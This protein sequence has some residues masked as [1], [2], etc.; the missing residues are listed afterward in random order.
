MGCKSSKPV[1]EPTKKG[2]PAQTVLAP[3][4]EEKKEIG[5]VEVYGVYPSMN[6]MGAVMLAAEEKCGKLVPTSPADGGTQTPA[7]LKIN[8]FHGV[9]AIKDGDLSL[10]ESNSIMRY[11]GGKYVPAL[12]LNLETQRRSYVDWAMDRFA[13]TLYPDV[14]KTIYVVMGFAGAPAD[15]EAVAKK[16]MENLNKF[17]EVFLKEKFIGGKV[18]SIADYKVAPFFFAYSHPK[19]KEMCGVELSERLQQFN[20]DFKEACKTGAALLASAEGMSIKE[21]LDAK[22]GNKA[23]MLEAKE[24]FKEATAV[25]QVGAAI[26]D[27]LSSFTIGGKTDVKIYGVAVS[28]NCVGPIL[29]G[30]H[31]QI[32]DMEVCMP[33]EQSQSDEYKQIVPF[34]GVPGMK[35]GKWTMGE[36][37]A[38]LRHMARSYA[39]EYYPKEP[40]KRAHIDW[41]MDRW[42]F[43]MYNDCVATIYVAMGFAEAPAKEE[44]QQAA[45]KAA[46][47]GLKEFADFF[48]KEKFVGGDKLSIADFKIA[49]F[50]AAYAHQR[51]KDKAFVEVPERIVKFNADFAEACP[52]AELFKNAGGFS[53]VEYL[54]SKT[55]QEQG[56]TTAEQ[57]EAQQEMD[58]AMAQHTQENA[59]VTPEEKGPNIESTSAPMCGCFGA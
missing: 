34:G 35:D 33:G 12:Y 5:Q 53:I 40:A 18:L 52:A 9:P 49:P 22:T 57:T 41:A 26:T 31:C 58:E 16:A 25:E 47:E 11:F 24:G 15:K 19:V 38:I 48:L 2:E 8:P 55:Q 36:S 42:S 37:S 39:E 46:S 23:P 4:M 6:C 43:G 56:G 44:E 27:F 10:A 54:D 45:G 51:V 21:I 28:M 17:A 29:F 30:R 3:A 13:S 7:F 1:V 32:G 14:V 59:I 50:F 20:F